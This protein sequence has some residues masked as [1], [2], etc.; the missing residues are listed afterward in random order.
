M[1]KIVLTGDFSHETNTFN[2]R[3]TWKAEF[4]AYYAIFGE[5]ILTKFRNVN[6]EQ[7]GF[8]DCADKYNWNLI[9]TVVAT[10]N[11]G[12]KVTQE[13]F[14]QYGGSILEKAKLRKWDGIAL[15]LHGAMVVEDIFDAEGE[16]LEKLRKIVGG[17]IPIAITLDLHA[18]VT[19][20]MCQNAN[21][22]VSYK[23]YKHVDMRAAANHAGNLLEQAMSLGK[24]IKTIIRQ[25]PQV[26]GLDSWRTDV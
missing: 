17:E 26:E 24:S 25:P 11:P 8:I 12:G 3:P 6:H 4:E 14:E 9:P 16:L 15:S 2:Q 19:E 18:N 13:A 10:A 5:Q 20:K 22:I 23:T 7:A 1:K 21:I